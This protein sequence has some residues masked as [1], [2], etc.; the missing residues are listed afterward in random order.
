[1]F[2]RLVWIVLAAA[3]AVAGCLSGSGAIR[4]PY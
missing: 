1:M 2:K 3:A 4:G